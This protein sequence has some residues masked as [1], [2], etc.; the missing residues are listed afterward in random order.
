MDAGVDE[1]GD[2]YLENLKELP[3]DVI[4]ELRKRFPFPKVE[5]EEFTIRIPFLSSGSDRPAMTTGPLGKCYL[6]DCDDKNP[7]PGPPTHSHATML[8]LT[9]AS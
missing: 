6:S 8:E 4:M 1:E 7:S 9:P 5:G 2:W 3:G